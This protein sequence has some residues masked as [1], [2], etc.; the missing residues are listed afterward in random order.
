MGGA[1]DPTGGEPAT[2]APRLIF[3]KSD[4]PAIDADG[5]SLPSPGDQIEYTLTLR[6]LGNTPATGVELVD[7]IP[8]HAT[9]VPGSAQVAGGTLAGRR[10]G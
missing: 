1:A 8:A 3:E 9:F 4:A 10:Y 5:D 7:P 6:N 2:A